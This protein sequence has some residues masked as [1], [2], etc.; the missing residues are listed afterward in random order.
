M[1][2]L[3]SSANVPINVFSVNGTSAV[4][5]RYRRGP[6]MLPCGTPARIR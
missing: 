6:R 5:I 4:N 2:L 1:T 3:L